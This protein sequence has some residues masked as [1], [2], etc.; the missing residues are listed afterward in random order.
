MKVVNREGKLVIP[1]KIP[2]LD[3]VD[4]TGE[5]VYEVPWGFYAGFLGAVPQ[6]LGTSS[7]GSCFAYISRY[8]NNSQMGL[9]FAHV[10]SNGET[11]HITRMLTD[12]WGHEDHLSCIVVVGTEPNPDST[13]PR[14]QDI[15]NRAKVPHVVVRAPTGVVTYTPSTGEVT[16]VQSIKQTALPTRGQR[17]LAMMKTGT[18]PLTKMH[19]CVNFD[20]KVSK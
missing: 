10:S 6:V 5:V 4:K 7:L 14:I 12:P 17:T 13:L 9:F 3:V 16:C 8:T 18:E 11:D 1:D 20:V 19:D 15:L 2:N